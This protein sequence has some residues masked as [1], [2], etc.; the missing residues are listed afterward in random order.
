LAEGGLE[1]FD[2]IGGDDV[3]IGEIGLSSSEPM[4]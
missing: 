4:F 1:G 3:G 2:D